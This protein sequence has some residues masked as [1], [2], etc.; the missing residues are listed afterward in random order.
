LIAPIILYAG[1]GCAEGSGVVATLKS[2]SGRSV[3]G[4]TDLEREGEHHAMIENGKY[5]CIRISREELLQQHHHHE[6][7]VDGSEPE[8]P[9]P[10]TT[11]SLKDVRMDIDDG[12]RSIDVVD[13]GR[14]NDQMARFAAARI[15]GHRDGSVE[16][17]FVVTIPVRGSV[18]YIQWQA[19]FDLEDGHNQPHHPPV[20]KGD[21]EEEHHEGGDNNK[22]HDGGE[23]IGTWCRKLNDVEEEHEGSRDPEREE[24]QRQQQHH[25]NDGATI[26]T[27][28]IVIHAEHHDH[29]APT[30]QQVGEPQHSEEGGH[31]HQHHEEN[32]HDGGLPS[33]AV[34]MIVVGCSLLLLVIVGA[35]AGIVAVRQRKHVHN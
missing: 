35:I 24:G 33:W 30:Q 3:H 7:E 32:N 34:V 8:V 11:F 26:C 17:C 15:D 1:G 31:Q 22:H 27:G 19:I 16:L 13:A 29:P 18:I 4:P 23:S 14:L 9:F 28:L 5:T 25:D 6:G 20:G 21:G 12:A 2:G 10:R